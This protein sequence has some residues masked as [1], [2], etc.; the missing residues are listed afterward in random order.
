MYRGFGVSFLLELKGLRG[1]G[2]PALLD[3]Q[4]WPLLRCGYC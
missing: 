1:E 3:L 2:G 4:T